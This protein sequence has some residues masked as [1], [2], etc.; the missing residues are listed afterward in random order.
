MKAFC[1]VQS[2]H[3]LREWLYVWATFFQGYL[4]DPLG[5]VPYVKTV[6]TVKSTLFF[7]SRYRA[8]K[9]RDNEPKGITQERKKKQKIQSTA[10]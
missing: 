6:C 10:R 1:V 7:S 4:E 9:L 2:N 8:K 3:S 5:R